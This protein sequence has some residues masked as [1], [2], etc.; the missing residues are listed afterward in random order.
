ML[1]QAQAAQ[2][3]IFFSIAYK[4]ELPVIFD[5][6]LGRSLPFSGTVIQGTVGLTWDLPLIKF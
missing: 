3:P 6:A 4:P 5:A 1:R 2:R